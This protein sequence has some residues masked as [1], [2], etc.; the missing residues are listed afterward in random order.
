MNALLIAFSDLG[1]TALDFNGQSAS[2]AHALLVNM[3]VDYVMEHYY[4]TDS[5]HD[6]ISVNECFT[7]WGKQFVIVP[8]R[9]S[10]T[11]H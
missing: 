10:I 11:L 9:H 1:V 6:I 3:A 8:V 4:P 5:E 7:H 2:W